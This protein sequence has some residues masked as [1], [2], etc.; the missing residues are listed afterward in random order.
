MTLSRED[1]GV[2]STPKTPVREVW[3]LVAMCLCSGIVS[4]HATVV[5]PLLGLISDQLGATPHAVSWTLSANLLAAAVFTPLIGRLGDVFGPRAVILWVLVVVLAGSLLCAVATSLPLLLVGR[6]LQAGCYALFPLAVSVMRSASE[7]RQ[8]PVRLAVISSMNMLGGLVGMIAAGVL[9]QDG[10]SYRDP[11]WLPVVLTSFALVASWSFVPRLSRARRRVR[12]DLGGAALLSVA[13]VLLLL[14]ISQGGRWGWGSP[15]ALACFLASAL[16]LW[17]WVRWELRQPEPLVVMAQLARP[18]VL[19][20]HVSAFFVGMTM[21]L[22][23][24]VM[25]EFPQS[26]EGLTGY[27][28]SSSLLEATLVFMAPGAVLSLLVAPFLGHLVRGI[29]GRRVLVLGSL[30]GAAGFAGMVL[31]HAEPWQVI[32]ASSLMQ[33]GTTCGYAALPP[34]LVEAVGP[35][36]TG[37]ANSINAISRCVGSA[38]GSAFAVALLAS[39]LDADTGL[40]SWGAYAALL[41]IGAVGYVGL[42]VAAW[43]GLPGHRPPHAGTIV[44]VSQ[45]GAVD[46][47]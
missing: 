29:G 39:Q 1:Q 31:W 7:P 44:A 30:T 5:V 32:V 2:P 40:A 43:V 8:L 20:P 12:L 21:Y 46:P 9:T 33:M 37:V 34:L 23:M 11:L 14:P 3:L 47:R 16:L 25:I 4:V 27:G 41:T 19:I 42:V 10:S 45:V 24:I 28:F 35:A 26:R 38:V 18:R 15:R 13:L 17:V 6:V 36:E 22:S